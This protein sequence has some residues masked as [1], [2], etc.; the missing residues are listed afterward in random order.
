MPKKIWRMVLEDANEA[1]ANGW[2][3]LD[4]EDSLFNLDLESAIED[5]ARFRTDM[6]LELGSPL[7]G[8]KPGPQLP[9]KNWPEFL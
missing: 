8:P 5:A 9:R 6:G 2:N 3:A 1:K 4:M 7:S